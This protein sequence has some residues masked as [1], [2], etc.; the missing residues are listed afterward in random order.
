MSK[1]NANKN[2][3]LQ[4]EKDK[5]KNDFCKDNKFVLICINYKEIEDGS[6]KYKLQNIKDR[7]PCRPAQ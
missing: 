7:N 2:Y 1:E 4:K 5:I 6:F 3:K